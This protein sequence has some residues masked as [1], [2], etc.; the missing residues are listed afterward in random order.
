M[1]STCKM[2]IK[3]IVCEVEENQKQNF[4]I[5][6]GSWKKLSS[7][8]GFCGQFGG[9]NSSANEAI[10]IGIW[11]SLADVNE[12]MAF[13]HDKIVLENNQQATY[14][15]CKVDY[16][17]KV[18]S[19]P[20]L[21]NMVEPYCKS[22]FR[23]SYFHG[24]QDI[25]HFLKNQQEI[26]NTYMGQEEGMLGVFVLKSLEHNDYFVVISHWASI[27]HYNNNLQNI[28][29]SLI[30]QANSS[31]LIQAEPSWSVF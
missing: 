20:P 15:Q 9:W 11:D 2:I 13:S 1:S 24:V 16:F 5:A 8:K 26:W 3:L 7:I 10:I 17:E 21:G 30:N 25:E 28:F 23:V 22:I 6:Q 19:I 4:S 18:L 31:I 14:I 12:F 29:P 27:E